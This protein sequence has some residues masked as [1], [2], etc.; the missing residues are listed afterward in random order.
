MVAVK[1][2]TEYQPAGYEFNLNERQ[3]FDSSKVPKSIKLLNGD[4]GEDA[5]RASAKTNV[6]QLQSHRAHKTHHSIQRV[7]FQTQRYFMSLYGM[8]SSTGRERRRFLS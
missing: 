6:E 7:T 5:A 4:V 3:V 2:L 1:G 8:Q